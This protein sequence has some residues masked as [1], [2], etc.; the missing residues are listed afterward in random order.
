MCITASLS[1]KHHF[2]L[3]LSVGSLVATVVISTLRTTS[4]PTG[5]GTFSTLVLK[6][7][8]RHGPPS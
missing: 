2:L 7:L 5:T 3:K 4:L 1:K 8:V 6:T